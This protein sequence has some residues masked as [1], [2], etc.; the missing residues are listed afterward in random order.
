MFDKDVPGPGKYQYLKNFGSD[1]SKF[2]IT[3]K[4]DKTTIQK[5]NLPGPGHYPIISINPDG[6]Y[7][8]SN[9]RNTASISF[10]TRSERFRYACNDY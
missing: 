9:F 1:A 8:V 3:G 4:P 5:S 10:N 2:S 7:P 6:K